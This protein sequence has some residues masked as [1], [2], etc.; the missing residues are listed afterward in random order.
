MLLKQ[1]DDPKWVMDNLADLVPF[2][3]KAEEALEK[4]KE[5]VKYERQD[6]PFN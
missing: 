5:K 2:V 1:L 4:I 6:L 3:K